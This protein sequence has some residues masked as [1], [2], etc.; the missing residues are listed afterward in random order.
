[1]FIKSL[2]CVEYSLNFERKLSTNFCILITFIKKWHELILII[3]QG[4]VIKV[5]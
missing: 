1:M 3:R 4:G 2:F 5:A